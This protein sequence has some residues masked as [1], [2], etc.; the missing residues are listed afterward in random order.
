[1]ADAFTGT[2]FK[3]NP[4]ALCLLEDPIADEWTQSAA[5]E[6]RLPGARPTSCI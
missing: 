5:T 4:A 3:G 2:A 6:P 1:M